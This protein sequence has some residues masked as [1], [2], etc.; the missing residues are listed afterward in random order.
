MIKNE[1][2]PSAYQM[3]SFDVPALFIMVL[4]D[5]MAGLTLK[6]IYGNKKIETSRKGIKSLCTMYQE[7]SFHFW[8]LNFPTKKWCCHGIPSW[9]SVGR[10]IMVYLERILML[11]LKKLMK[12]W[13]R[14]VDDTITFIKP[15]F[16]E[17]H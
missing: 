1:R 7:C 2:V 9:S 6:G 11:K 5:Y 4:L 8:N 15:D 16:H 14:Y 13:K 17:C 10:T 3:I 12:P